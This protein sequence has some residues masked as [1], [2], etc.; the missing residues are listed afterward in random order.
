MLPHS[1]SGGLKAPHGPSRL[2]E[3]KTWLW[4]V[5][6]LSRRRQHVGVEPANLRNSTADPHTHSMISMTAELWRTW[7]DLLARW[8]VLLLITTLLSAFPPL[9]L[10]LLHCLINHLLSNIS[11]SPTFR[12]DMVL[13]VW[14]WFKFSQVLCGRFSTL[15]PVP[16]SW[17]S[18]QKCSRV[19]VLSSSRGTGSEPSSG[20]WPF[21]GNH[22][23]GGVLRC[24]F[25]L[26]SQNLIFKSVEG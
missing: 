5:H 8:L 11:S 18:G 19:H 23:Y 26:W 9:P 1:I 24:L 15:K 3:N 13:Q 21:H 7:D 20:L 17:V 4:C 12:C 10:L 16:H 6:D 25:S 22:G 14:F 2:L